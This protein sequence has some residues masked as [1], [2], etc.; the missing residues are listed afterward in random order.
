MPQGPARSFFGERLRRKEDPRLLTGRGLYLD[1]VWQ[2]D[3]IHLGILRSAYA[4]ANIKSVD[5]SKALR[6]HSVVASLSGD[7]VAESSNPLPIVIKLPGQRSPDWFAAARRT[8]R[9]TGEAICAV[10][11][12]NRYQIRD[13]IEEIDVDYEPLP[14]VVDPEAALSTDATVLHRGWDNNVALRLGF[15][16]GDID[17]AFDNAQF[18]IKKRYK[19]GRCAGVCLETRGVIADYDKVTKTL[20]LWSSTQCPHL[21]RTQLAEVLDFPENRIRIIAPEIGG[22]FG[23]KHDTYPEEV[24]A[25]LMSMKTGRPV[26]WVGDRQEEFLSTVQAREQIHYVEAAAS[27]EGKILGLRDKIIADFG[28]YLHARTV[29]PAYA[30]ARLLLG[31]YRIPSC[32]IQVVGVM[33]NKAPSGAY[34]GYGQPVAAFVMERTID[35]IAREACLDPADVRRIN[36]LQST[37]LPYKTP[38][39]II[40][41]SGNYR[42]CFE[43]ALQSIEYSKVRK[44]QQNF[45]EGTWRLGIGLASYVE[46]S[47]PVYLDGRRIGSYESAIVRIDPS[48][49]ATILCGAMPHGQSLETTLSQIASDVLGLSP[50]DISVIHGDTS[51]VPY[52]V[53]TFASR[54]AV[55]AGN[56]VLIASQRA[57]EKILKVAAHLLDATPSEL[58]LENGVVKVQRVPQRSVELKE[59]AEAAYLLMKLPEDLEPGLEGSCFYRPKSTTYS[60]ATHVAVVQLDVETGQLDI[61]RYVISHDCGKMINP[62]IIEGQIVGG[63][64]Q[65][66]GEALYEELCYENDSGQLLTTSLMDYNIIGSNEIPPIEIEHLEIPSQLNPAGVKGMGEGGT[67]GPPPAIANAISDALR[68]DFDELPITPQKIWQMAK[69]NNH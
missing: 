32:D 61:K 1:D 37:E 52:G 56:A 65:G 9:Y 41:D 64:A 55:T 17:A 58:L 2:P 45:K 11:V 7:E 59:I 19:I 31:P 42:A 38:T 23:N 47:A 21:L 54:S 5:L 44:D 4:H 35:T 28:S 46:S 26:K 10:A 8:A 3:V 53:G 24:L 18:R 63:I 60:Y 20:T 49:K 66:L 27:R 14:A 67:I 57:R 48:G 15:S 25:A 12:E 69:V 39:G 30:T 40:L 50:E 51:S 68:F 22:A 16:G 36:F 43:L 62:L 6:K 13:V 34:R 29:G 33:T